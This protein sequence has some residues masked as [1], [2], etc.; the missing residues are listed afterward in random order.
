MTQMQAEQAHAL[1]R[2]YSKTGQLLYVGITNNPGARF[3]QHQKSKPWWHD[4][5]GI[6]VE[7]HSTRTDALAAEER[8][9]RVERPLKNIT[10]NEQHPARAE[11]PWVAARRA[12]GA[13]VDVKY[14]VTLVVAEADFTAAF[15]KKVQAVLSRHPGNTPVRL[16]VTHEGFATRLAVDPSYYVNIGPEALRAMRDL[17]GEGR[18]IL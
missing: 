3:Q 2:F 6:S 15:I 1:Y 16:S 11:D 8:A 14:D 10:H 12:L 5:A 18:V 9:I 13:Q 17:V 4:V 7:K